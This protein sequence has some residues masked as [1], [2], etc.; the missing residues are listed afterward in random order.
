MPKLFEGAT[1]TPKPSKRTKFLPS[2]GGLATTFG[3]DEELRKRKSSSVYAGQSLT[4]RI[5]FLPP[6]PSDEAIRTGIVDP[7]IT[8]RIL[9]EFARLTLRRNVSLTWGRILVKT[10]DRKLTNMLKSKERTITKSPLQVLKEISYPPNALY[11]EN[12]QIIKDLLETEEDGVV[13]LDST[14]KSP[15]WIDDLSITTNVRP[16]KKPRSKFLKR[17]FGEDGL[18]L[19]TRSPQ[20][21]ETTRSSTTGIVER[22]QPKHTLLRARIRAGASHLAPVLPL[23]NQPRLAARELFRMEPDDFKGSSAFAWTKWIS[24]RLRFS[25]RVA[26]E[27]ADASIR[28]SLPDDLAKLENMT[29]MDYLNAHCSIENCQSPIYEAMYSRTRQYIVRPQALREAL[30]SLPNASLE[31]FMSWL[32]LHPDYVICV[33]EFCKCVALFD[34]L[35]PETARNSPC[36]LL[37]NQL[38]ASFENWSLKAGILETLDFFGLTKR[39][40]PTRLDPNLRSVLLKLEEVNQKQEDQFAPIRN[41]KAIKKHDGHFFRRGHKKKSNDNS[42]SGKMTTL[43]SATEL[44]SIS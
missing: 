44:F 16:I 7:F 23:Q 43:K 36:Q 11:L 3:R 24:R 30:G 2:R 17:I 32:N 35:F 41:S 10:I 37:M 29:V 22:I 25:H 4:D 15:P 9:M 28:F 31:L 6:L 1:R 26:R 34:R 33:G 19:T 27:V 13:T 21:A 18:N 8:R 40:E 14:N 5:S 39:L 38:D 20:L 12:D 42:S